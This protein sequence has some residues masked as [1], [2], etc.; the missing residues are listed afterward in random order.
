M[1]FQA[2]FSGSGR[3]ALRIH[4]REIE[5]GSLKKMAL[6]IEG[7]FTT[8]SSGIA[9]AVRKTLGSVC[10]FGCIM[11]KCSILV[12]LVLIG[13]RAFGQ[14][15]YDAGASKDPRDIFAAIAPYYN[16]M[17]P[18]LKPWHIKVNYQLKDEKFSPNNQGVFE[19]WWQS[20]GVFRSSWKR[21]ESTHS[22]WSTSDG[23]HFIQTTGEPLSVYE[24]WLQSALLSPLPKPEELDPEK[25]IV[26]D[27][28]FGAANNHTR[29][30]MVVPASV[31]A[32]AAKTLPF[33]LYPEYC[34][35]NALPILLGYYSFRSVLVKCL[36]TIKMQGKSMP[37]ELLISD[38]SNEILEAQVDPFDLLSP[39]DSALTPPNDARQVDPKRVEVGDSIESRLLIRKIQPVYPDD[40]KAA[41]VQGKVVLKAL[42]GSDGGVRDLRL[43]SA[44][45]PS[46]ALSAFRSVSQWQYEPYQVTGQ[47][48]AVE[49]TV[50][51][52]FSLSG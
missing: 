41:H 11:P 50:E 44:P 30:M 10:Y 12:S 38:G 8:F 2:L 3:S 52:D 14:T 18:N 48:A 36:N 15:A 23:K 5:S 43:V 19:Y 20:P 17:D 25:S 26:V 9:S 6:R 37:R 47:P 39:N 42:I 4:P 29:C 46:L 1:R 27:H 51:V 40:A 33:G 24:Y 21:G 49:T 7:K 35:N 28:S 31:T 16:F 45:S 13:L 32:S 34:V 22:E